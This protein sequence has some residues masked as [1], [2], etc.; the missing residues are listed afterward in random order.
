MNYKPSVIGVITMAER[1]RYETTLIINAALEDQEIDAV[2]SKVT[3]YIEDNGGEVEN[4]KNMGRRRLAYPINKKY[5]GCYVHIQFLASS[6]F[7]TI[8][9]KFLILED[10]ILRHLNLDLPDALIDYRKQRDLEA[11]KA[12]AEKA[13]EKSE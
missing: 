8:Y 13:E 2:I 12:T 4:V 9:N 5:N 3:K 7:Q 6:E 11:G 1:R 10:T